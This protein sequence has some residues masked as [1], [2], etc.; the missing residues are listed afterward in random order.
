MFL[1]CIEK[2]YSYYFLYIFMNCFQ[3]PAVLIEA[4]RYKKTIDAYIGSLIIA[5]FT[6]QTLFKLRYYID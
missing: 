6:L 2:T 5:V 3:S 1:K 4:I